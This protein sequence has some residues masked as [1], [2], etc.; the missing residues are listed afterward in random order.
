MTSS[1][2]SE[3]EQGVQLI[4]NAVTVGSAVSPVLSAT[5]SFSTIV[6]KVHAH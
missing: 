5:R 2:V 3:R 4:R 6:L 1:F